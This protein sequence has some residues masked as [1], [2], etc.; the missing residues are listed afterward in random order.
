MKIWL[1]ENHENRIWPAFKVVFHEFRPAVSILLFFRSALQVFWSALR[2]H[3][4]L[5]RCYSRSQ[6]SWGDGGLTSCQFIAGRLMQNQQ[7]A[8]SHLQLI[9][10]FPFNVHVLG[11]WERTWSS[12]RQLHSVWESNSQPCCEAPVCQPLQSLKMYFGGRCNKIK[13]HLK[14]KD[15]IHCNDAAPATD[16]PV[17]CQEKTTWQ[18]VMNINSFPLCVGCCVFAS[19]PQLISDVVWFVTVTLTGIREHQRQILHFPTAYG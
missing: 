9:R 13:M 19:Q 2:P 17:S 6:M 11:L 15:L 14:W 10:I 4:G 7:L 16:K 18:A 8:D 1:S 12:W 5:Q 3:A